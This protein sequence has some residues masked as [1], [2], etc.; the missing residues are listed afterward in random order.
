MGPTPYASARSLLDGMEERE[1]RLVQ[2][3]ENIE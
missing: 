1:R 2:A 3:Q